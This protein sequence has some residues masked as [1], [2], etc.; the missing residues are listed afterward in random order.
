M[1]CGCKFAKL[2]SFFESVV[3]ES[4]ALAGKLKIDFCLDM[5]VIIS[6]LE[7][8]LCPAHLGLTLRVPENPLPARYATPILLRI[9]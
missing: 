2:W 1:C 5:E 8:N 4:I 6:L 9:V 7:S 3:C